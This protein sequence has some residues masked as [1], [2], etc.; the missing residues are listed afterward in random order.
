MKYIVIYKTDN[1]SIATRVGPINTL[2]EAE[3]IRDKV[4]SSRAAFISEERKTLPD[5][6][7]N[8]LPEFYKYIIRKERW[9]DQSIEKLY[10]L[11]G[12]KRP[13]KITWSPK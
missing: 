10:A 3:A 6:A 1:K 4:H 7:L 5:S 8:P 2:K 12:K 9:F 13:F 11:C